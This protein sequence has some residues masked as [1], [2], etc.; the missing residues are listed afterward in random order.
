[1]RTIFLAPRRKKF[2][3]VC[4]SAAAVYASTLPARSDLLF[5]SIPSLAANPSA[6][7]FCSSCGGTYQVFDTFTLGTNSTI[8]AIS[9]DVDSG[10]NFDVNFIWPTSVNVSIWTV[11]G[12]LPGTELFQ[13]TYTPAQF[14]AVT[15][16]P[17]NTDIVTVTTPLWSLSAGTYDISFYNS[18]DLG[19]PGYTGG[20][21]VLYQSGFGVRTA[22][23][24]GFVLF[25]QQSPNPP[26]GR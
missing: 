3:L 24:A 18:T 21:G 5:Q 15:P 25:H 16:T 23:S 2:L 19:V 6:I 7:A 20:S 26:H 17:Y 8:G 9:F 14:S 13:N 1:M 10:F 22:Q 4:L 12:A 11:S